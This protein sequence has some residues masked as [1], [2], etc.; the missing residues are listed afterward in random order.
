MSYEPKE[1]GVI[2]FK[3]DTC[4]GAVKSASWSSP[5]SHVG[6]VHITKHKGTPVPYVVYF[7]EYEGVKSFPF[8]SFI[9][10]PKTQNIVFIQLNVNQE[11]TTKFDEAILAALTSKPKG[12]TDAEVRLMLGIS[13]AKFDFNNTNLGFVN[14]IMQY[15]GIMGPT[16]MSCDNVCPVWNITSPENNSPENFRKFIEA[17][18]QCMAQTG[19]QNANSPVRQIQ[20][21]LSPNPS[22]LPPVQIE[23]KAYIYADYQKKIDFE[24]DVKRFRT[25]YSKYQD[26]LLT[27]PN[28]RD[29]YTQ[30]FISNRN[31][32]ELT[33]SAIKKE[34]EDLIRIHNSFSRDN[35]TI[36]EM[37][38][39]HHEAGV[40]LE[41]LASRLGITTEVLQKS[42]KQRIVFG[43]NATS[44]STYSKDY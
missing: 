37:H 38:A 14:K 31:R 25:M 32:S 34:V 8:Q 39:L 3:L 16:S 41:S 4:A 35:L 12:S 11:A 24:A 36:S 17:T 1:P 21:Y 10:D 28:V 30:T 23:K 43:A 40:K 29:Y 13:D 22:F 42:D 44:C 26:L 2:L 7:C 19:C 6:V 5:H 27:H 18:R 9:E 20:F 33:Q 15:A